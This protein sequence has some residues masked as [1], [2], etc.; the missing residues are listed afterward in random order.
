M[1]AHA[2]FCGTEATIKKNGAQ[3]PMTQKSIVFHHVSLNVEATMRFPWLLLLSAAGTCHASPPPRDDEVRNAVKLLESLGV[4]NLCITNDEYDKESILIPQCNPPQQEQRHLE[5]QQ[6]Q[7]EYYSRVAWFDTWNL[8]GIVACVCVSSLAAGLTVCMLSLDPLVLLIKMRTAPTKKEKKQAARLVAIVK[9]RHLLLVSLILC[10]AVCAEALPIFL[11]DLM[12]RY[13]AVL[14]AVFLV[15]VF[16]EVLPTV[17]FTGP[18]QR[19][20]AIASRWAPLV[21][22]IMCLLYPIAAPIAAVCDFVIRED[23]PDA[24]NMYNR[25]ELAALI[26]IQYE[27][28]MAFKR[29]KRKDLEPLDT[30]SIS[31][32]QASLKSLKNDFIRNYPSQDTSR[33]HNLQSM[34][35]KSDEVALVEGALEMGTKVAM[36]IFVPLPKVFA[37]PSDM[38]LNDENINRI[39]SSAYSRIPV[40]ERR[41]DDQADKTGII[42]ILMTRQLIMVKPSSDLTVASLRI[43]VPF[44]VSPKMNLVELVNLFQTGTNGGKGGH[45]ALVCARPECGN[46]ALDRGVPVPEEA[47]PIGIITLEDVLEAL[48]Q[49]HIYDE[50]DT[51]GRIGCIQEDVEVQDESFDYNQMV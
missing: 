29:R 20:V 39:Y 36:D 26:R 32:K 7:M 22:F 6:Q 37:I 35:L 45:M 2:S 4:E 28:R 12:P 50:M 13:A 14:V 41:E 17:L 19:R 8:L 10:T 51:Q 30:S 38:I 42:G 44:C 11:Q 33:I 49:E 40:Y 25:G 27:E 24:G 18:T 21:Q 1:R 34:S 47:I 3:P 31:S 16:G 9:R 5:E 15:V 43:N 23:V 48:L 46:E